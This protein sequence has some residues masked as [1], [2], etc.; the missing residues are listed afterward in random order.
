MILNRPT[1]LWLG[2]L[3]AIFNVFVLVLAQNNVSV[4]EGIVIAVNIML[5]AIISLIAAQPP[6]V[7]P[8]SSVVVKTNNGHT[9]KR[10]TFDESGDATTTPITGTAHPKE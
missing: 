10:I 8:S 9:D 2:A 4:P 5:A 6:V 3:Q 1:N 7:N